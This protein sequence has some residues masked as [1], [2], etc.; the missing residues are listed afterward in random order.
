[1]GESSG[2]QESTV[3]PETQSGCEPTYISVQPVISPYW[4][5]LYS[6]AASIAVWI[7]SP[8]KYAG[9]SCLTVAKGL[10]G[11]FRAPG[12]FHKT[13]TRAVYWLPDRPI[14]I[15]N[16]TPPMTPCPPASPAIVLIAV[17]SEPPEPDNRCDAI[18]PPPMTSFAV[19]PG[20][21]LCSD[22]MCTAHRDHL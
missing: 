13:S 8:W 22:R 2:F 4:D 12:D 15:V 10:L 1:M 6:L 3:S 18:N 5:R 17:M 14:L 16:L 19:P 20:G 7:S 11:S 21:G 9:S